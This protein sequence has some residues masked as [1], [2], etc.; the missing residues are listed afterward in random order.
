MAGKAFQP[1]IWFLGFVL[2]LTIGFAATVHAQ[3]PDEETPRP[4]SNRT[5]SMDFDQVDIK[6]FIKFMSEL[7][8]KNFVVD[9][10]VRGKVTVLSPTKISVDE[11]Y[12][13]FL[14]VLE[15]NGFGPDLKVTVRFD[16]VGQKKLLARYA[17]L[18]KDYF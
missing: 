17:D 4:K 2:V 15:V 5:I 9:D 1:C 11:A 6:V 16:T 8:G 7:T 3:L 12:R 10:K 13:V 14:S 18:E